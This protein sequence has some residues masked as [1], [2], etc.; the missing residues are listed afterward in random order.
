[1]RNKRKER[2]RDGVLGLNEGEDGIFASSLS[3]Q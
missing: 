3:N 1:M 2:E